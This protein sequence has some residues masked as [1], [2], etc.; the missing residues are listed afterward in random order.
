MK[1]EVKVGGEP[2]RLELR[3]AAGG[4]E[5]RLEGDRRRVDVVEVA[6]GVF[7]LLVEGESF[8]LHVERVEDAYRVHTRGAD[9][10]AA[11]ENPRRWMRNSGGALGRAGRQEVSAPMPGK[12]VRVLVGEGQPVESHQGLVVV[13]AMKMQNEIPSPKAGVVERVLVREGDTVEHGQGLVVVA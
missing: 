7:S 5:C 9:L 12:V 1:L 10:V 3:R 11:V 2:R 8:T 13:E 6:P 4:W